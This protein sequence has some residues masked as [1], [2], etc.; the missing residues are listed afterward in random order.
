LFSN[1]MIV[2][3]IPASRTIRGKDWF[4]Y[5]VPEGMDV[6]LGSLVRVDFRGRKVVGLVWGVSVAQPERRLKPILERLADSSWADPARLAWL[7][8]FANHYGVSLPHAFKLFQFPLLARPRTIAADA[9]HC[10]DGDQSGQRLPTSQVSTVRSAAAAIAQ[11]TAVRLLHYS[12]RVDCLAVYRLLTTAEQP[13]LTVLIVPEYRDRA[14]I[15]TLFGSLE[16]LCLPESPSASLLQALQRRLAQRQP[17]VLIGTRRLLSLDLAPAAR[18]ILDEESAPSHRQFDQNPRFHPR[19]ALLALSRF[20]QE[21]G[22]PTPLLLT[23]AAPSLA[24]VAQVSTG[25]VTRLDLRRPWHIGHI[26]LVDMEAEQRSGNYGW[27]SAQLLQRLGSSQRALLFLNRIG[28]HAMTV[29]QDCATLLPTGATRCATC[30][31]QRLRPVRRGTVQLEAELRTAFPDRRILRIDRSQERSTITPEAVATADI[32]LGTEKIF[33]HA[34]ATD[35]DFV[36]IL[37]IDHLLVYPDFRAHERVFGLLLRFFSSGVPTLLQSHAPH[38][39]VI[40]AAAA[41][42]ADEFWRS[43]LAVRRALQL[44][45]SQPRVRWI[46]PGGQVKR[47]LAGA[48]TTTPIPPGLLLERLDD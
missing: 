19:T 10:Q 16:T 45:P 33:S 46:A 34:A 7:A 29:C 42:N 47:E 39:P 37:S 15:G 26:T 12:H 24:L 23:S 28:E 18:I 17:G 43:E 9:L 8:W 31:G 25:A 5:R 40:A 11:D 4:D 22:R 27:F 3:V 2:Q 48:E 41:N 1:K 32:V 36:G 14:A 38:H 30:G 21:A 6:P 35:F 13:G 20:R 44:P